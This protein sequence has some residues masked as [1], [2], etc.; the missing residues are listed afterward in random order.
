MILIVEELEGNFIGDFF[1]Y[2]LFCNFVGVVSVFVL[3]RLVESEETFTKV[4]VWV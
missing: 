1:I 4:K 2:V 3:L